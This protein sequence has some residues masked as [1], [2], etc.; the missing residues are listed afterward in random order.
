MASIEEKNKA[1]I[2]KYFA[3][4]WAKQNPAIVDEVCADDILQ[5]YPMHANPKR[6]KEALKQ[7]IVEFKAVR[8]RIQYSQAKYS[9]L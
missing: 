2:A 9:F 3:E 5:F 1:I 8:M 7:N 4:Y 6:G